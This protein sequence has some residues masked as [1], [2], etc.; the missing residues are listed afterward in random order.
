[1]HQ[2]ALVAAVGGLTAYD[3]AYVIVAG[4]CGGVLWTDDGPV[5]RCLSQEASR[6]RMGAA[7]PGFPVPVAMKITSFQ[8]R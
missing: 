2:V 1:M 5:F 7:L 4:E 6:A 8:P 3:A